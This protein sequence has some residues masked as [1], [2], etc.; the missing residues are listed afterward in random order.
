[1]DASAEEGGAHG[2]VG[3]PGPAV[4][5]G[6]PAGAAGPQ[7]LVPR[8][9]AHEVADVGGGQL[10]TGF[11]FGRAG[12]VASDDCGADEAGP[13]RARGFHVGCPGRRF[14]PETG[15]G[16][17]LE[18]TAPRRTRH[19]GSGGMRIAVHGVIRGRGLNGHQPSGGEA[20]A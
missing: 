16:S 19:P 13:F 11:G 15:I 4:A 10:G 18:V 20:E 7:T 1:M 2:Q 12:R 5:E 8:Q 6:D 3:R 9:V 17:D 14:M